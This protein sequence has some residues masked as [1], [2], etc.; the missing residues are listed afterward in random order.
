MLK[1]FITLS[2]I[3]TMSSPAFAEMMTVEAVTPF[4]TENPT[5]TLKVKVL[6]DCELDENFVVK[7][8]TTITGKT[9][10]VVSPKRLKRDA[11]FSFIPER[12]TNNGITYEFQD[13]YIGKYATKIDKKELAKSASL[14]VGNF[15]VQGLSLGVNAVTGAIKNE[16][17]N[18]FKSS[19]VN[20]YEHSPFSYVENGNEL[21]IQT[22]DIF[23]LKFKTKKDNDEEQPNY[24]Y[25]PIENN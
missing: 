14:T 18:R 21:N 23:Y 22:G 16:E 7:K 12:Y 15:F 13:E 9:T 19:A 2:I 8:G 3:L 25:T 1:K 4:S 11:S 17:G 24:E 6:E 10:D 5:P 20:V